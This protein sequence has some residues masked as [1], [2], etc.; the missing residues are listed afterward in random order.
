MHPQ[1]STGT[2][3]PKEATESCGNAGVLGVFENEKRAPFA[4][5]TL[6]PDAVL[7]AM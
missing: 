4:F 6:N 5:D 7:E 3:G 2:T 1:P